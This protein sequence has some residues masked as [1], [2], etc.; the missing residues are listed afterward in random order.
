MLFLDGRCFLGTIVLVILFFIFLIYSAFVAYRTN[1][2][3]ES[4]DTEK[5][6]FAP[7]SPYIT[8]AT[9]IIWLVQMIILAPWSIFFG[10]FL[11]LFPFILI[12]FRP[13]PKDTQLQR[14][15]LKVGNSVLKINTRLLR[16][17]G[18]YT[19]PIQFST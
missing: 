12:V 8:P 17:L 1:A 5:K 15:I 3:R 6:N 7:E 4:D 16:I 2:E 9:P 14:F 11:I 18:V 10:A 19:K 13:F